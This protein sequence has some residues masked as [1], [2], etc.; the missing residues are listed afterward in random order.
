MRLRRTTTP[1][2]IDRLVILALVSH[3]GA[4]FATDYLWVKYRKQRRDGSARITRTRPD[5]SYPTSYSSNTR[6]VRLLQLFF[7]YLAIHV[8]WK[9]KYD[10]LVWLS[11][12][13]GER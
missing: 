6:E 10:P 12:R 4:I 7:W 1:K 9:F 2:P 5:V 13:L 8:T 11:R 3:L